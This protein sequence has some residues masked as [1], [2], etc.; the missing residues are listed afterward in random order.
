MTERISLFLKTDE[1]ERVLRTLYAFCLSVLIS[2]I[3][4]AFANDF[5]LPGKLN[6]GKFMILVLVSL[7][8]SALRLGSARIRMISSA[9]FVTAVLLIIFFFGVGSSVSFLRSYGYWLTDNEAF[10]REW[11]AGYGVH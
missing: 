2:I 6:F 7:F 3:I 4:F 8:L 9:F 5:F 1:G 10:V 11:A